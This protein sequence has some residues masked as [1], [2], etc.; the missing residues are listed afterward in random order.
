MQEGNGGLSQI[1]NAGALWAGVSSG[2][3]PLSVC[4]PLCYGSCVC[5]QG[6]SCLIASACSL[7]L[8]K[9]PS[10]SDRGWTEPAGQTPR[11]QHGKIWPAL[12]H[13]YDIFLVS[14]YAS[15]FL[16]SVH[17]S[18]DFLSFLDRKSIFLLL[19][20]AIFQS[21]LVILKYNFNNNVFVSLVLIWVKINILKR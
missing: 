21:F 10:F 18:W 15:F 1:W 20:Q 14:V 9:R 8:K 12:W 4:D 7:P 11:K 17:F 6:A 2:I 16:W 5:L 3:T 19:F 13:L